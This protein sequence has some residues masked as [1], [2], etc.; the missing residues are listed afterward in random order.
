MKIVF[1]LNTILYRKCLM[2]HVMPRI[3]NEVR[4]VIDSRISIAL[5]ELARHRRRGRQRIVLNK[6]QML[7]V[8][9]VIAQ[10]ML[11]SRTFLAKC[12]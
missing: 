10:V 9:R 12:E 11:R 5:G 4:S 2:L 7:V 1:C 8:N 3:F 6:H